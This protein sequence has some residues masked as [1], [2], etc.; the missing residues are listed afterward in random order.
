MQKPFWKIKNNK[1]LIDDLIKII[2]CSKKIG[3]KFIVIPLVDNGLI[4]NIY[5]EKN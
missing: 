3:V 2:V 1:K 4:E 5:H